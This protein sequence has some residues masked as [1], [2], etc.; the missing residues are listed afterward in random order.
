MNP[1]YNMNS[2]N[3]MNRINDS[4]KKALII[5]SSIVIAVLL[6][7]G[8]FALL[9]TIKSTDAQPRQK[10]VVTN[11]KSS[12]TPPT[13]HEDEIPKSIPSAYEEVDKRYSFN[14]YEENYSLPASI[15]SL[16][17]KGWKFCNTSDK[18]TVLSSGEKKYLDL[19]CPGDSKQHFEICAINFSSESLAITKCHVS[20]IT[21]NAE[22]LEELDTDATFYNNQFSIKKVTAQELI[23]ALGEP[24]YTNDTDYSTTY[25]FRIEDDVDCSIMICFKKKEAHPQWIRITHEVKP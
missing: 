13:V 21:I 3:N 12:D 17:D 23:D 19:T 7:L 6:S 1:Y 9:D 10:E 24:K 5:G 25:T 4:S 22:S 16:L 11:T 8:S 2:N 18:N 14:L 20:S 15:G